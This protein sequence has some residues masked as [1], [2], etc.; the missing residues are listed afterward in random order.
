MIRRA[1][2][3]CPAYQPRAMVVSSQGRTAGVGRG[4][5]RLRIEPRKSPETGAPKRS[6]YAEGTTGRVAIASRGDWL[7]F[8]RTDLTPAANHRPRAMLRTTQCPRAKSCLSPFSGP[9][10]KRAKRVQATFRRMGP[11]SGGPRGQQSPHSPRQ[12]AA[13]RKAASPLV[14]LPSGAGGLRA[15]GSVGENLLD[16]DFH[17]AEE[18][19]GDGEAVAF[20]GQGGHAH[21]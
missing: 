11:V 6:P 15:G 19:G 12:A 16:V 21:L 8:A 10:A 5:R 9:A 1:C 17:L 18:G 20:V 14:A 13:M 2:S 7:L 4:A 3:P